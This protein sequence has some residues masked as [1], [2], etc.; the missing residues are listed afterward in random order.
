MTLIRRFWPYVM[1]YKGRAISGIFLMIL[2]VLMD[3]AQPLPLKI[4]FDNVF[5]NHP[6]PD[7]LQPIY[8]AIGSQPFNL[9][10][11]VSA[12]IVGIAV[13]DGLVSYLGESRVTNLGQRVVF[14]MRRDL[15]AH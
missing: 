6:V 11:L 1:R 12:A 15:Y 9:L 5:G 4:L 7:I 13:T 14:N 8:T 2:M 3:L 10:L